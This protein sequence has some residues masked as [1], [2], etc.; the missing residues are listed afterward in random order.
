MH[1]DGDIEG[2]LLNCWETKDIK[3]VVSRNSKKMIADIFPYFLKKIDQFLK[4]TEKK[5]RW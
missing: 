4:L 2:L 5:P 1:L 3:I